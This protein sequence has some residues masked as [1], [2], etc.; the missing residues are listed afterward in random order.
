MTREEIHA[1]FRRIVAR[2]L[3]RADREEREHFARI[4][5]LPTPNPSRAASA[6]ALNP[7]DPGTT[8]GL[9]NLTP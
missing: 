4:R 5:A 3:D 1:R 6:L 2:G 7:D 9:Y 8:P